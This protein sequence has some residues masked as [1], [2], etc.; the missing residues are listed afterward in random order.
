MQAQQMLPVPDDRQWRLA[1]IGLAERHDA[2]V[3]RHGE[4]LDLIAEGFERLRGIGGERLAVAHR[5]QWVQSFGI[6]KSTGGRLP[7]ALK[8]YRP[9]IRAEQSNLGSR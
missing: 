1:G 3:S 5:R 2:A 4:A 6:L 9:R 7:H 8:G